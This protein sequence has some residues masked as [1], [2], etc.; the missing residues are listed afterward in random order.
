[1]GEL[2][3]FDT[4]NE[5][6]PLN[7]YLACALTGLS[8][9]QRQLMFQLSDVVS[10][11]CSQY[12]IALYEPRKKTDPVH[13]ANVSDADVFKMDR[14]RVLS[15]DLLIHLSHYP[16]TGSGQELDFA[17]NALLPIVIISH[18]ENRVSRMI[19]GIPSYTV[20]LKYLEPEDLR[21]SLHSCLSTIRPVLAERKLAFSQYESHFVG[22]RLRTKREQLGLSRELVAEN[23]PGMTLEVLRQMEETDDKTSNPSLIHLRQ[24]AYVLKTTVAD[25]V[26]DNIND[27]VIG[28]LNDWLE[29]K[30]AARFGGL[31]KQ[32]SK[33]ILRR[34]LLRL[35]DSL[36]EEN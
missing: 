35:I 15:S 7:A 17:Y 25:L 23:I 21:R 3:Q 12:G 28:T 20:H 29:G 26:E 4:S 14:E 32:D 30:A 11:I 19:T 9:E 34:V 16:S 18:D 6:I 36:E 8:K 24:L 1:M 5:S 10:D 2:V 13:H 33:K 31:N 22:E 27:R